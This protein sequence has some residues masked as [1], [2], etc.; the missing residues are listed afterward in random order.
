MGGV[1]AQGCL[2]F[3]FFF[4]ILKQLHFWHQGEGVPCPNPQKSNDGGGGALVVG[5][6][7]HFHVCFSSNVWS[8][9]NNVMEYCG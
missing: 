8:I 9:L 2:S 7:T 3:E 1:Y 5:Y 4:I 6:V